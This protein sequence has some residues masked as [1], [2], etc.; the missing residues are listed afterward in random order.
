MIK[1]SSAT[2]S[3]EC[4]NVGR[5]GD[6]VPG[7]SFLPSQLQK[8]CCAGLCW[9]KAYSISNPLWP[10]PMLLYAK[11]CRD[12]S[13]GV[14]WWTGEG[15]EGGGVEMWTEFWAL[16]TGARRGAHN[17]VV[18][19]APG[20]GSYTNLGAMVQ[21]K[22]KKET[23]ASV[24]LPHWFKEHSARDFTFVFLFFVELGLLSQD[25]YEWR[26]GWGGWTMQLVHKNTTSKYS[27]ITRRMFSHSCMQDVFSSV[28][29]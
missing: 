28:V 21:H 22:L 2:N 9:E 12:K 15:R 8:F 10:S 29:V 26:Q 6:L 27:D 13:L 4:R 1:I 5:P 24:G 7:R 16:R 14:G 25:K 17:L 23:Q 11:R 18:R 19:L 20:S 3:S